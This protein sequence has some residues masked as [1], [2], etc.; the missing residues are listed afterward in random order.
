MIAA[1]IAISFS[2][3]PQFARAAESAADEAAAKQKIFESPAW[4]EAMAGL[5][6]W[7]SVQVIYDQKEVPQLKRELVERFNKMSAAQLQNYL[8]DLQEKL[9]ILSSPE[10]VALRSDTAYNLSVAS[11]AYAAK[12]RRSLPD[13][14]NMNALQ[15]KQALY[16][17]E[18]QQAGV[19]ARQAAFDQ[20][21]A[22]QVKLVQQ[23]NQQTA[24]AQAAA[25]AQMNSA[26]SG[27]G[28]A[29]PAIPQNPMPTYNPAPIYW[30]WGFPW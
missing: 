10:A 25:A 26:P 7:F 14:L 4:Q 15:V 29:P 12:I 23:W 20:Q 18:Q 2:G 16:N 27:G 21:R 30:G 3:S 1:L 19:K 11:T 28:Y 9:K 5:N 8:A 6:A 24:D 13:V 22:A 17:A